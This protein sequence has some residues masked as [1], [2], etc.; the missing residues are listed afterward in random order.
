MKYIQI[1]IVVRELIN[2]EVAVIYFKNLSGENNGAPRI[3]G[4]DGRPGVKEVAEDLL[5]QLG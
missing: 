5:K 1:K 4:L 3:V 2:N